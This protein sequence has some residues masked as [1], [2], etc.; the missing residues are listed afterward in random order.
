[1]SFRALH[2]FIERERELA[3]LTEAL[4]YAGSQAPGTAVIT[5]V[6]GMA[7]VGKTAL[8]LHWAH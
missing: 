7:G 5:A 6:G 3:A 4:D 8:A 2:G 1:V